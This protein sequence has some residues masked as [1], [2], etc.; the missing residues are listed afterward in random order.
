MRVAALIALLAAVG[1]GADTSAPAAGPSG[2]TELRITYW[3]Q[4][5]AAGPAKKWTLSCEPTGGTLSQAASAC[6]KLGAM[7][8]PFAPIPRD[9]ICTE[10]YGGPQVAH[11]TGSF[12]GRAVRAQLARRNGCEISRFDRLRFLVPG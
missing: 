5:R 7:R 6:R 2:T 12:R 10:L 11:I 9:A 3:P 8:N 4:G 1:C